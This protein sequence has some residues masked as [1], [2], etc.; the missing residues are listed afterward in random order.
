MNK[1]TSVFMT[2]VLAAVL[3]L[4]VVAVAIPHQAFAVAQ[5]QKKD[6]TIKVAIGGN[7]GSGGAG[8]AGG[9]GGAGGTTNNNGDWETHH[10]NGAGNGGT[11]NNNPDQKSNGGEADGGHGGNA[12]G[13]N[14]CLFK[15]NAGFK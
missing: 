11:L 3:A 7:G 9:E 4:G 15:C 14:A 5:D 8:G 13:G 2:S 1:N 12:D 6:E 10:E